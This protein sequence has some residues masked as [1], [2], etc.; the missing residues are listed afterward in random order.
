MEPLHLLFAMVRETP[1]QRRWSLIQTRRIPKAATAARRDLGQGRTQGI[2]L[3]HRS[4]HRNQAILIAGLKIEHID[5]I[6]LLPG[7]LGKGAGRR[8]GE[9]V[10]HIGP[11]IA[12]QGDRVA[13]LAKPIELGL[14]AGRRPFRGDGAHE[15]GLLAGVAA[16]QADIEAQGR[17]RAKGFDDELGGINGGKA[18]EANLGR[19]PQGKSWRHQFGHFAQVGQKN[20]IGLGQGRQGKRE[21]D[22]GDRAQDYRDRTGKQRPVEHR[23]EAERI[24]LDSIAIGRY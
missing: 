23:S 18:A 5:R 15:A 20:R 16:K 11:D 1:S 7:N 2:A 3:D 12:A 24:R 10:D 19:Q 4:G 9:P 8:F 14:G 6:V 17:A 21:T 22:R 13:R